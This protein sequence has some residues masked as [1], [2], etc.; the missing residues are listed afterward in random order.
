MN[1]VET[2]KDIATLS[3]S[4]MDEVYGVFR[5]K[6]FSKFLVVEGSNDKKMLV[7]KGYNENHYY[8]SGMCGKPLV[9]NSYQL[10]RQNKLYSDISKIAFLIDNDFD[11]VTDYTIDK[12]ENIFIHSICPESNLH[13]Y[14][15]IEGF[16]V[17]SRS[18][19]GFLKEYGLTD[20][21]I[22]KLKNDVELESRRIGKYRAANELIKKQKNLPIEDTVIFKFEIEN[23][24]DVKNFLFL[25]ND[26]KVA[27]RANSK[28]KP[29]V[30]EL[31]LIA[32][33]L[34]IDIGEKWLLSR[35]HDI[36][37]LISLYM[38]DK[39][40]IDL[41]AKTIERYLR[42]SVDSSDLEEYTVTNNLKK[43]FL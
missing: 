35:G 26:F 23:F 5:S 40:S 30:D 2:L 17:N 34:N 38:F 1:S 25:E 32:D 28:Y 20:R 33:K 9:L 3:Q 43:Y 7:N 8:F 22:V 24:F 37:E 12:S 10:F 21:D 4:L 14:N 6:T 31:F 29:L 27:V 39:F 16:L 36:T 15:D 41:S 18:L 19:I 42:L 11:H 13:Y